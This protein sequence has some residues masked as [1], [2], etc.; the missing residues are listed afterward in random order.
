MKRFNAIAGLIMLLLCS[1]AQA[2]TL[3]L[4]AE[5]DLL[6][7]D[8]HKISGFLLKGADGLELERGEHQ[9]LFRVEKTLITPDHSPVHWISGKQIVTFTAQSKVVQIQLPPL[10]SLAALHAFDTTPQFSLQTEL[11][12][13]IVIK[14]DSLTSPVH[15]DIEQAMVN[16]NLT[17]K[18]ASVPR[19]AHLNKRVSARS[20]RNWDIASDKST[21][22]ENVLHLWYQQVDAATRQR[23]ITL[24][25]ALHTS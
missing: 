4:P 15:S 13:E 25:K 12:H 18:H 2:T 1:V 5:L 21:S 3:K 22:A 6:V 19:F 24:M 20:G 8:G 9:L 17:G 10:N 23:F 14:R 16:Y 7:L 11:G